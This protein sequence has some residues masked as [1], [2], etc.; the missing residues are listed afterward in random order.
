M[1]AR[2]QKVC[3]TVLGLV[4]TCSTSVRAASV[5]FASDTSWNVLN[6]SMSPVGTAQFVALN[7]TNPPSFPTGATI[8]G[9]AGSGWGADLSSIPGANWIWA[10]GITGATPNASLAMYFFTK[11]FNLA[12]NP[13][14]ST[15]SVTAD[16]FA[17]VFVNG[18]SVGTVGSITDFALS[19]TDQKSLHSFN[20]TPFLVPGLNTIQIEGQNGPA[21]FTSFTNPNYSQNP[22][23]VVFGGTLNFT[24]AAVPEPSA[25]ILFG[26]GS[27][28]L[29]GYAWRR[30]RAQ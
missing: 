7:T 21:S 10:P 8:Y 11:T 27:L 24:P 15:L 28:G 22:A 23:G 14:T 19:F 25:L 6:S 3:F 1:D 29:L 13:T 17:A 9:F 5:A 18:T 30:K 26:L 12:G 4:L 2:R 16:D 20:I